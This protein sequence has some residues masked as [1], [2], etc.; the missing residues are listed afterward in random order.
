MPTQT[1]PYPPGSMGE[2]SVGLVLKDQYQQKK[3]SS[4]ALEVVLDY[5]F[6]K[7]GCHRI[8]ATLLDTP[9]KDRV[10]RLFTGRQV[11][12]LHSRRLFFLS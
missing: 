6:S 2:M 5:A 12:C 9:V 11:Y 3:L 4:E 8:Q 7:L 10:M 1:P